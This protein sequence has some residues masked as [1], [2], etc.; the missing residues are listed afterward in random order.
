VEVA[1]WFLLIATVLFAVAFAAAFALTNVYRLPYLLFPR[2]R[3]RKEAT[4][5]AREVAIQTC[6][7]RFPDEPVLGASI[8][9]DEPDRY[10]VRVFY[11][12][13]DASSIASKLPPWRAYLIVAVRKDAYAGEVIDDDGRYRPV[14]R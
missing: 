14:I 7:N 12:N 1:A 13:R 10:V 11:G 9:S 8:C 3:A 2:L 5:K 6:R 4:E